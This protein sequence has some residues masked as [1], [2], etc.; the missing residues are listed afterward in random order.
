MGKNMDIDLGNSQEH[1]RTTGNK[2]NYLMLGNSMENHSMESGS[3][4]EMMDGKSNE[5]Q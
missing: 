1:L 3:F 2:L 5:E 4:I